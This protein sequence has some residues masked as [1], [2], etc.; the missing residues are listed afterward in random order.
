[1]NVRP[2]VE[3][4]ETGWVRCRVLSFLESSYFDDVYQEKETFANP[5]IEL[6]V[7]HEGQIV[8]LI[9]VELDTEDRQICT[10][11]D[12]GGM[13]WHLAVHPDIQRRGIAATLFEVATRR[14][15]DAGA[16][17]FEAWTRDDDAAGSWY[18]TRGFERRDS[19]LHVYLTREDANQ[20]IEC[21][22]PDLSINTAFAQYVGADE[23]HIRAT[24]DRVHDC[25]QFVCEF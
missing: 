1:M 25:Q 13:I 22:I 11:D 6:V 20:V 24:F 2:Y 15:R 19:Y 3:D 10:G 7:E 18:S 12:A 9:D 4:D 16:V 17:Y 5:A 8:G 21:P 14:A 23:S